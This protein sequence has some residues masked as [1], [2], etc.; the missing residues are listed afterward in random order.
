M[1]KLYELL[2]E[3]GKEFDIIDYGAHAMDSM[4]IEK[5]Y[6][7]WGSELTPEIS[8]VEAGLERFLI[9]KKNLNLKDPKL[10]R[11]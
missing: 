4:R 9:L 5:G 10:Y 1:E 8:V 6:R 7:G 2:S 3:A 11:I